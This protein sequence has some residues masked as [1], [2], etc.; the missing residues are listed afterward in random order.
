MNRSQCHRKV[1]KTGHGGTERLK[2]VKVKVLFIKGQK[3][4]KVTG[5]SR[6]EGSN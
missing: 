1:I 2:D 5:Y 4:A 3:E 6:A